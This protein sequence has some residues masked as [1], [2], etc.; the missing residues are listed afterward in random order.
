MKN[1]KETGACYKLRANFPRKKSLA[2][3]TVQ[4][5][6]SAGCNYIKTA[7]KLKGQSDYI[8]AESAKN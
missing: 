7:S 8:F 2:G 6:Y 4:K 1:G 5:K 3:W